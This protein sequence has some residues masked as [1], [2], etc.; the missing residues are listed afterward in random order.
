MA[1]QT[2]DVALNIEVQTSGQDRVNELA[3]QLETLA[4]EG[5]AAAPEFERLATE[6]RNIGEQSAAVTALGQLQ[7][8]AEQTAKAFGDARVKVD[9]MDV[10][11]ASQAQKTQALREQQVSARNALEQ[12][13]QQVREVK[14][15]LD[16]LKASS[17]DTTKKTSD[18]K[19]QVIE[20]STQLARLKATQA[21]ERAAQQALNEELRTSESDL[22]AATKAFDSAS[23][24]ASNLGKQ[25]AE[26]RAAVDQ[27]RASAQQAGVTATD[28]GAA[29]D[30]VAQSIERVRTEMLTMI[31]TQQQAAAASKAL[32]EAEQQLHAELQFEAETAQRLI[33]VEN[34]QVASAERVAA[35]KRSEAE[36]VEQS[37]RAEAQAAQAAQQALQQAFGELGL[38]STQ[39]ITAEIDQVNAALRRVQESGQLTGQRLEQAVNGAKTRLEA[40]HQELAGTQKAAGLLQSAFAQFTAGALLANAIQTAAAQVQQLGAAAI[41]ANTDLQ[42]LELG[43]KSVFGSS[44]VAAKQVEFLRNVAQQAGVSI[45][46]IGGA[47]VK[48]AA[49]AQ[50][51]N[52]PIQTTNGLFVALTKNAA[53]LGL[54]GDKVT[55]MLNA[56]GQMA[57]KGTVQMEELRGQLGDALPGAL[58]KVAQGLGI[59]TLEMEK[60]ARNG[61]LLA[62]EVFPALQKVLEQSSGEVD[63]IA[64]K[65]ARFK[66]VM[67]ETAQDVGTSG[68][69]KALGDAFGVVGATAERLAFGV[70]LIGESFT[71]T[72]K[73]IG[74]AVA[75]IVNQGVK[76]RGFSDDAKKAFEEI[77]KESDDKLGRLANRIEGVVPVAEQSFGAVGNA[78]KGSAQNIQIV[79]DKITYVG[80]QAA[81]AASG[82]QA[83]A[84]AH[85]TAATAATGNASAQTQAGT[86]T[87]ASG[88]QA[89]QS[90]ASWT[91][92]AVAYGKVNEALAQQVA[93][94]KTT[95]EAKKAEG[96]AA[97]EL[98][99]IT[100]NEAE[101]R[102]TS[103]RA[104]QEAE[105]AQ[106]NY[107]NALATELNVL[108]AQRDAE[109]ALYN[110]SQQKEEAQRKAIEDISKTIQL[111]AEELEKNRQV[112]ESLKNEVTARQVA[113]ETLK[114]NSTRLNELRD[115][116][117]SAADK[118]ERMTRLQKEGKAT[119]EQLAAAKRDAA[120]AEQLYNDALADQ[121]NKIQETS[122]AKQAQ[123]SLDQT[124]LQLEIEEA[125]TI[126]E[127][128]KAHGNE[129]LAAEASNRVKRLQIELLQLQAQAQRAEAEAVLAALPAKRAQLELEGKLNDAMKKSLEAEELSAKAKLKQAQITDELA[130]RIAR[131]NDITNVS[132]ISAQNAAGGFDQMANAMDGAAS[133]ADRLGSSLRNVRAGG[134][135]YGP[136]EA[137]V[138]GADGKP[139]QGVVQKTVMGGDLDAIAVLRQKRDLGLLSESDKSLAEAAYMAETAN[140]ATI[141][142][143]NQA[144]VS[145]G[146]AQQ[147]ESRA[148]DAKAILDHI[149][150]LS[151]ANQ[152]P[153][154][155]TTPAS[156]QAAPNPTGAGT[157]HTVTINLNGAATTINTST[158]ADAQALS[159]LLQQLGNASQRAA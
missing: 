70:A 118:V 67:T 149:N 19:Q 98:S 106:E 117:T 69:G 46:D 148:R 77:A 120:R 94:A 55:D 104:A 131:V 57:S 109:V 61:E 88:Q 8:E 39:Q 91:S 89:Q 113:T 96:A 37:A 75:D 63:T 79:G 23:T 5:G 100:V 27:A 92:V 32:A 137:P 115:A 142:S 128:A 10:A 30:E 121:I 159:S 29:E 40:L 74:V 21:E 26:Q 62:S 133:S 119:T 116:Y 156:S 15:S 9:E 1:D 141:S 76:F 38:R 108:R 139:I 66:N 132:I 54:S 97:Q 114:D 43:L 33:A 52:I 31:E 111:K 102:A 103:A 59:T 144:F 153:P 65:W 4:K 93:L 82:M 152:A 2:R 71:V 50:A 155:S 90:S 87:A 83:N 64:A 13:S 58:P 17:D 20:L 145:P 123:Y 78:A 127:V 136:G 6:L 126:E 73:Q 154:P 143:L 140:A 35:A 45:S 147:A 112:T 12:T 68:L 150:A 81:A 22:R 3:N 105:Q 7:A 158:A 41:E 85:T 135:T 53:T 95:L 134:T 60:L 34:E 129:Q 11:L 138:Q 125:K 130:N 101:A 51:A 48:F 56:L 122:R 157:S 80:Q 42:K 107:T 18:Y 99:R 86:A 44:D 124:A 151:K 110:A 72:G 49:S 25:M 28:L 146:V 14:A 47:Y 24:A 36:A 84:K 16:L